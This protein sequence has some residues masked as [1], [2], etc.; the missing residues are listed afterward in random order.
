MQLDIDDYENKL[1]YDIIGDYIGIGAGAHGKISAH[2]Q[3]ARQTNERHPDSYM[4]KI[5][6]H[7]HAEKVSHTSNEK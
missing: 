3:I 5:F 6:N 7:G 4:D 2:N 1:L